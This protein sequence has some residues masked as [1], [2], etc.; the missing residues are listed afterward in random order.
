MQQAGELRK[1]IEARKKESSGNAELQQALA[2]LEKKIEVPAE[3]DTDAEF[4]LFGLAAPG[5]VHPP[6]SRVVAALTGMLAIVESADAAPTTDAA[7][8][9]EKWEAGAQAGLARWAALQKED[10]VGVNASLQ[11]ANLKALK[12]VQTLKR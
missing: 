7:T 9:S 1:Q 12:I 6:L 8:A 5:E 2:A 10:I 4:G 11:R 3:A